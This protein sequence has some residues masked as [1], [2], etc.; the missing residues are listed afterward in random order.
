[1]EV[2][3]FV[4][5]S[6]KDREYLGDEELLGFLRGLEK[7]GVHFWWDE[8]LVPGDDF[9]DEIKGQI[10][11]SQ[12]AVVLVSQWFLDSDYCTKV[13]VEAFLRHAREKGLVIFP[14]ILSPCEW[15]R[16]EWLRSRHF[17]PRG[18]E[19]VETDYADPGRRKQ[20]Y[21][22]ARDQLRRQIEKIRGGE[23]GPRG[24]GGKSR[25]R[26]TA[27]LALLV[28]LV[29]AAGI[30]L[31]L[32]YGRRDHDAAPA[33]TCSESQRAEILKLADDIEDNLRDE[34]PRTARDLIE[35]ARKV[36]P[37]Y[38]DIK[39]WDKRLEKLEHKSG[40]TPH[41]PSGSGP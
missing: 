1:M 10:E 4:S 36:C 3:V 28:V 30:S 11:N 26:R 29:F 23:V 18:G 12:I 35:Q 40:L 9:D 20:L 21:L 33:R 13:E 34:A 2:N 14:V 39:D 5:Y 38:P 24:G 17:L 27:A 16:H 32:Y 25:F 7:E 22:L 6:H 15:Q 37:D 41:T 8:A 19:T 31:Y